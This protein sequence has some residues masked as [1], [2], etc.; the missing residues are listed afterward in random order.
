MED[1]LSRIIRKYTNTLNTLSGVGAESGQYVLITYED[2]K[3]MIDNL[4]KLEVSDGA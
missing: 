1:E 3:F 2:L 4:K